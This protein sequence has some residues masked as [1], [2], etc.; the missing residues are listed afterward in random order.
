[1]EERDER[2][3][4][5]ARGA[6]RC[7]LRLCGDPLRFDPSANAVAH[8]LALAIGCAL[9][10]NACATNARVASERPGNYL[11]ELDKGDALL[12][13]I[14]P[15]TGWT[16][17]SA[18]TAAG[19]HEVATAR[20]GVQAVVAEYGGDTPGHTLAVYDL[21]LRRME[22]TIDLAPH[23][24]PHGIA[25]LDRRSTVLVTSET[26]HAVLEV[27][28]RARRVVRAMDTGAVGS[29]MLVIAPDRSRVF[30]ANVQS[31]SVSAIDLATGKLVAI[32]PTGDEPEAIDLTPDGNELWVGHRKGDTL[33]VIDAHTMVIKA[34]VA[35]HHAPIRLKVTPD[36]QRVL[37]S[38]N[39]SGD[40]A[41]FD[42][43]T[44][45]EIGRIP[46][47]RASVQMGA[48]SLGKDPVPEGLVIDPRGRFA[49]VAESALKRV[50]AIDLDRLAIQGFI[51]TGN[52]PDGMAWAGMVEPTSSMG[53]GPEHA[54]M[55]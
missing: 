12:R 21:L 32:V 23:Q 37:V 24:R 5:Q 33:A 29:H 30:T 20:D 36:G 27:D 14:E 2:L 40:V 53:E 22:S 46:L 50:T 18:P 7:G 54:G 52:G 47:G 19:P 8:R 1:M 9:A 42:A 17:D 38:N 11:I 4:G 16:K 35:C 44:R 51:D 10:L 48:R 6:R 31:G 34:Q 15:N 43:H 3:V 41:V 25:Y 13:V 45:Q 26:S 55:R 49:F 39:G 28:L